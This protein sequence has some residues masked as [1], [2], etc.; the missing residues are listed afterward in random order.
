VEEADKR[1]ASSPPRGDA[2]LAEGDDELVRLAAA[3]D[4]RAWARLYQRHFDRM[5]RDVAYLVGAGAA[6]EEIVQETFAIALTALA[7]YDARA[8]VVTW[9]HGIA[10]NLV[11][12]HWR[13][14]GRR[15]RAYARLA[16]TRLGSESSQDPEDAHLRARRAEVLRGVLEGVPAP[17][18]EAFVL[19]DVQGLGA[20]EVAT[21]LG[22]SVGNVRVRASRA[23]TIIRH[24]LERLG[25]IDPGA[26][27]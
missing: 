15:S 14:D 26:R 24:E 25:W 8:S 13:S 19:C 16:K 21:R 23:R 17:L 7:R 22:I 1:V 6:A 18:R 11:R 3:G 2:A 12:R 4:E 10:H 27:A 20:D 5:F 9:L